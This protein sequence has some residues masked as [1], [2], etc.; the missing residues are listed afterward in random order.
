MSKEK[1]LDL[2]ELETAE[3]VQSTE[4]K[5]TKPAKEMT[6]EELAGIIAGVEKV[7]GFG[8]SESLSKVL[9]LVAV[10]HDKDASAPV[11]ASVIESFGGSENFKNYIDGDFQEELAVIAGMQKVASCLNNIKSFYARRESTKKAKTTQVN[12]GGTFYEVNAD[13]LTSLAGVEASEKREKLLAHPDT[14]PNTSVEIL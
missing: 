12:I 3:T 10:W 4:A 14:K 5:A 1:G 9:D 13:F 2:S 7:K 8:V 6:P 11:K